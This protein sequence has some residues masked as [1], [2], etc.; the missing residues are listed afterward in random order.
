MRKISTISGLFATVVT[1]AL[2]PGSALAGQSLT[3][4]LTPPPPAFEVCKA[5][6]SGTLCQGSRVLVEPRFDTGIVCGSAAGA[7]DIQYGD[8]INQVASRTYNL[9]GN[10]TTRFIEERYASGDRSRITFT[11]QNSCTI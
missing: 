9:D 3:Q 10:L 5:I 7:F 1:A 4:T 2:L 11:H 6:G 8:T